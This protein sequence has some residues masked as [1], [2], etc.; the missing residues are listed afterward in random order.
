MT[1]YNSL[2]LKDLID[3]AKSKGITIEYHP[4]RSVLR[5]GET[6]QIIVE[7]SNRREI[8]KAIEEWDSLHDLQVREL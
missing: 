7:G 6:E 8:L 1:I 5:K 4:H 3:I 2:P